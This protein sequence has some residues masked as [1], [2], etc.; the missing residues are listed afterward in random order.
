MDFV[1]KCNCFLYL[2]WQI[3]S[4]G[5]ENERRWNPTTNN[6]P[7]HH[8]LYHQHHHHQL[9]HHHRHHHNHFIISPW[10]CSFN[11]LYKPSPTKAIRATVFFSDPEQV[12][13]VLGRR[14]HN[15]H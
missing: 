9:Y 8:H 4:E 3:Y 14:E 11:R 6:N 7:Q 10:V 2:S 5:Q 15:H 12:S 1:F 13:S